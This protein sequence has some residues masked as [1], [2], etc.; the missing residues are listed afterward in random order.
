MKTNSTALSR[1]DADI[2]AL[3]HD[4]TWQITYR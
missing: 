4:S 1:E 2:V 3:Y